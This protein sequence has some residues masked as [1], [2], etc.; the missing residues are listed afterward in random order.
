MKENGRSMLLSGVTMLAAFGIWTILIQCVD[1][2]PIGQHGTDIGFA[3]LNIWFHDL[4][5]ANMLLYEIT[6]WLGLV[7]VFIC[8]FF[9]GVGFRQLVQRKSLLRVDHDILFLGIYYVIVI[10][11]YLV[12]EMFPI[13]YRPILIEGRVE[14][15]YPS[16]TT[17]LVLSVMPTLCFQI[18]RRVKKP[19]FRR[20]INRMTIIFS[21]FMVTGRLISGVHWIT[22]I[23]GAVLLSA[24]LF[25]MYRGVVILYDGVER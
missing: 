15:S 5:G 24:G 20:R 8:M 19:V 6:D 4:I 22:D 16:S 11:G 21:L 14:S 12:F 9:G 2:Q 13:N 3:T 7:P 1:V 25:C 18:S 10:A 23:T 17:L